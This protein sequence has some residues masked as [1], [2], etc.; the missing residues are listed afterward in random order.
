MNVPLTVA[1]KRGLP[2]AVAWVIPAAPLTVRSGVETASR[3]CSVGAPAR[4]VLIS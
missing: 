2:G 3:R 1:A 4:P